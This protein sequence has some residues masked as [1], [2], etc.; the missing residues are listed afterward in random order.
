MLT[1]ASIDDM[2]QIKLNSPI[3]HSENRKTRENS[4]ALQMQS[5]LFTRKGA[6]EMGKTLCLN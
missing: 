1:A 5:H 2:T 4:I 3:V 6:M